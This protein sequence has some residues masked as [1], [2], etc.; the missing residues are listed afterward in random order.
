MRCR[1]TVFEHEFLLA[2][3]DDSPPVNR[4]SW[5]I[6][7]ECSITASHD[8]SAFIN[9]KECAGEIVLGDGRK[10]RITGL[11]AL[12]IQCQINGVSKTL[13]IHNSHHIPTLRQNIVSFGQLKEMRY[14]S[15]DNKYS[16]RWEFFD[17]NN[18]HRFTAKRNKNSTL[19]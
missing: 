13:H 1:T 9:Y 12:S 8:K 6:E 2:Y 4:N 11:G 18:Q 5:V 16:S 3:A 15:I 10:A 14:H 7:T 17:R 19:R